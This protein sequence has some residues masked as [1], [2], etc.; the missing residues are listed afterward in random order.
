MGEDV[1][2]ETPN[3]I[4]QFMSTIEEEVGAL[5]QRVREI[6]LEIARFFWLVQRPDEETV[7]LVASF[8]KSLKELGLKS[9]ADFEEEELFKHKKKP[10]NAG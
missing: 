6:N 2:Q 1:E 7:A 4:G 3:D 5:R 10:D 8:D 9:Y